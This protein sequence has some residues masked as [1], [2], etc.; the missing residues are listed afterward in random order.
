[1]RTTLREL[2]PDIWTWPWFSERHGYDFNG[3]LF[4]HGAGNL[5]VDPVDMPDDVLEQLADVGV[6]RIL[7]T[8]RNHTRASAKL[9]ERT[10]ARVA[11]HP[12]D[13]AY[14]RAQGAVIDDDLGL[15]ERVG[16]FT[17]VGAD[18]KSPGEVAL[19]WRERRILVIGDACVG[20]PPG[21]CALLPESVIDDPAA[22]R[23]TLARLCRDLDF[24]ALLVGDGAPILSGGHAA[25]ANLV[26]TFSGD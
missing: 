5:V 26:K 23:R 10:G 15:G 3:Y 18:G 14:A 16:P 17:I 21:A 6:A 22:L 19:H 9:R 11:I 13:A 7:I 8:N 24:D 2:L 1:V 20:K 25:L 4:R 12:A